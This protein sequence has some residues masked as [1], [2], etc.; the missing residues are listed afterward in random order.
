MMAKIDTN[1]QKNWEL[2]RLKRKIPRKKGGE[3]ENGKIISGYG[4][5]EY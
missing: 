5:R 4:I 3:R 2:S 1:S